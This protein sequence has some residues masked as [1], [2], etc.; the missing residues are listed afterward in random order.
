V[1]ALALGDL[2]AELRPEW[3]EQQFRAGSAGDPVDHPARS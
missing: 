3:G 1:A 2:A